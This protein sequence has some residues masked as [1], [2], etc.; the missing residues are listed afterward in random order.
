MIAAL[1]ASAALAVV[2]LAYGQS[3]AVYHSTIVLFF[4]L[5]GTAVVLGVLTTVQAMGG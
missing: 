5:L 4:V 3:G 2:W 1:G